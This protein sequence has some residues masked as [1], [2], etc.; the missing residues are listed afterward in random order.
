M[1]CQT[2]ALQF[3]ALDKTSNFSHSLQHSRI[4]HGESQVYARNLCDQ[5]L[6]H[7]HR[8]NLPGG[9]S[10]ACDIGLAFLAQGGEPRLR[11]LGTLDM[12]RGGA[13]RKVETEFTQ[14]P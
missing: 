11:I 4:Y 1:I 3:R 14:S 2:L 13:S 7:S 8:Y 5:T 10:L 6:L 9:F 12:Q